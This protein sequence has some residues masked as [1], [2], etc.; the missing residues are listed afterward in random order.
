MKQSLTVMIKD[1]ELAFS[2]ISQPTA[3]R[4][5]LKARYKS[6]VLG[7]ALVIA[8]LNLQ[9]QNKEFH[10]SYFPDNPKALKEARRN[11]QAG[12]KLFLQ[13]P[14]AYHAALEYYLLAQ[15]FNP[16]NALLNMRI[17]EC[18]LH[19]H[20]QGKAASYLEK[21]IV[22]NVA[23]LEVYYLLGVAL[24]HQYEFD[25]AI[26][27]FNFYRQSLSP[28][29]LA[30]NR[31]RLERRLKECR[32]AKELIQ[33]P[34]RV[35]VDLL[36][37]AINSPFDDY[38]P[39]LS[40][41]GLSL[42]FTSRRPLKP[43][44]KADRN[45]GKFFENI[46]VSHRQGEG[47]SQ[48]ELLPGKINSKTH[49]ATAGISPDGQSLFIYR[50][51]KGG[52]LYES[53]LKND[54]WQ[55]PRKLPKG[56]NSNFQETSISFSPDNQTVYLV[57]NRAGGYGGK[58]IWTATRN[59]RGK[60]SEPVNL[61]ATVNTPYD[62]ES[63]FMAPDGKTLYFSSQGHNTMGGFDIFR[64]SFLNGRWTEPV[65]L[66][67]PV[68]TP[69]EDLFLAMTPDGKYGF[70]SSK[71]SDGHGGSA[72]YMITFLGPEKPLITRI[73]TD[74]IAHQV[75]PVRENLMASEVEIITTPMTIIRGIILDDKDETPL[76]AK[77]QLFD[78]QEEVLLAEFSSD[79][80]TGQY[81]ISLPSGKNYGIAVQVEDY[82][83]HSENM[84]ITQSAMSREIINNIRLKKVEV[85]QSI[86]LNNIFF[87]SG[88][89][90]LRPE[91]YAELG[92][93]NKLMTD[94]PNLKIEIAG[95]TDNVGSAALNKRLSENRAKA[96]VDFLIGRG[97]EAHRLSF[98]GYGFDK[99]IATNTTPEGRQLNRRTE[100]EIMEK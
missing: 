87:D 9:A 74:P 93:L 5:H 94:N 100:F 62:E 13:K 98:K 67:F 6:L 42:Y 61:G 36:P 8:S 35:F 27:Q 80:E 51:D 34:I 85:G 38:S 58:D 82:L 33:Q 4:I 46:W 39:L 1:F 55:K 15:A 54:K 49:E 68:N 86:V 52:H 2:P 32:T 45:D 77:I 57:S 59:R 48:A 72:L 70:Y 21:A 19:S 37:E 73:M 23:S 95:H 53:T 22:L 56:I 64:T 41:D 79:A 29:L 16:D 83:F 65:N 28:Q 69:A 84:D 47:W 25:K 3:S 60:W 88:A 50:G 63:V 75:A 78:N 26:D 18:Y 89:S 97:I 43:K 90:T 44:A 10:R 30:Q 12:D 81:I 14:P 11:L 66:G 17:G 76:L 40:P 71:R 92:V 20:Q 7:I 99:P 31:E 96:V 91:S 24:Q